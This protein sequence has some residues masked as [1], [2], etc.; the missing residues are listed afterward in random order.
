M[1]KGHNG[2]TLPSELSIHRWAPSKLE[3]QP[4]VQKQV[5]LWD[6][7]SPQYFRALWSGI[8]IKN[9]RF[10][11]MPKRQKCQQP[12]MSAKWDSSLLFK[13]W[14]KMAEFHSSYFMGPWR[15]LEGF[16]GM[17]FK[18]SVF[19]VSILIIDGANTIHQFKY[20]YCAKCFTRYGKYLVQTSQPWTYE[21]GTIIVPIL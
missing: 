21:V 11:R 19:L 4:K 8:R 10:W 16:M 3:V 18:R 20:A 9:C 1:G 13:G 2:L 17:K 5:H 15:G 12:M 6:L 7:A 14:G